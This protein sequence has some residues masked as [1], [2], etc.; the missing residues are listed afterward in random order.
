MND[1]IAN[2]GERAREMVKGMPL[3]NVLGPVDVDVHNTVDVNVEGGRLD[4]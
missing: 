3:V 4:N 1:L 2:K